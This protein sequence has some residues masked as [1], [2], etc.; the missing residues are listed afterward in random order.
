MLHP[1][2]PVEEG[3]N[4]CYTVIKAA[5]IEPGVCDEMYSLRQGI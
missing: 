1:N 4:L 2:C 5:H 3:T